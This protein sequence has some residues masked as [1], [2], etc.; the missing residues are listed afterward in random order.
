MN[1]ENGNE[2]SRPVRKAVADAL[3]DI[4]AL[5][6]LAMWYAAGY[7][8]SRFIPGIPG[9]HICTGFLLG[10]F[11]ILTPYSVYKSVRLVR[12]VNREVV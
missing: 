9:I 4:F 12:E 1:N 7:V 11:L 6:S 8:D 2:V 5:T 3:L 10:V